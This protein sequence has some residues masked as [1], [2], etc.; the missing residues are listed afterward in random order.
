M[1]L[2]DGII[3]A[4]RFRFTGSCPRYW[5]LN[6]EGQLP[7][8]KP[9]AGS[10]VL[11]SEGEFQLHHSF[12]SGSTPDASRVQVAFVNSIWPTLILSFGPPIRPNILPHC[13][14]LPVAPA[15]AEPCAASFCGAVRAQR[16]PGLPATGDQKISGGTRPAGS[17]SWSNGIRSVAAFSP[18]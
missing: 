6:G 5:K 4:P 2:R 3:P 17:K 15:E 16:R 18:R 7:D 1:N 13:F 11:P 10:P 12:P 9:E 14:L 8:S